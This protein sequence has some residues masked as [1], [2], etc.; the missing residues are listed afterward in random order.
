MSA[1]VAGPHSLWTISAR[2]NAAVARQRAGQPAQAEALLAETLA[3]ARAALGWTHPTTETLR[4]HLA[5]C[6]LDLRRT[7]GVGRLTD[8]LSARVLNEGEIESDWAARLLYERGRLEL[9]T[10][11]MKQAVPLLRAAAKEIAAKDPNGPI[12]VG[13]IQKLIGATHAFEP[14]RHA[15]QMAER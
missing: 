11:N 7:A 5:D 4:Y 13:A 2:E 14:S 15:G 12:S 8:G 1:R 10:G 6:L 9:Y 3:V